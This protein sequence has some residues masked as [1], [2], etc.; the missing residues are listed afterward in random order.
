VPAIVLLLGAGLWALV[1]LLPRAR[2]VALALLA[3]LYLVP[4]SVYGAQRF[5]AEASR[6]TSHP[7]ARLHRPCGAGRRDVR[8]GHGTPS[9]LF[10]TARWR[11]S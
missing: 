2:G 10:Y 8:H 4:A 6:T 5:D 1:S 9:W 7:R 3:A 11:E